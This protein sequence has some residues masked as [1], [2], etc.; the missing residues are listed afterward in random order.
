MS[1]NP[2]RPSR[3][4]VVR[5]E[6]FTDLIQHVKS[7]M[8]D[9][10]AMDPEAGEQVGTSIVEFLSGHWAGVTMV[11]PKDYQF[12]VAKRDLEIYQSHKGDF[13]DTA[14]TWGMTERGVRKV[15]ERVTKRIIQQRQ[16]RLFD[17]ADAKV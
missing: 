2:F 6:M 12:Q 15:I 16:G 13:T 8:V 14:R 10:Y 4:E 17:D 5:H 3:M 7:L 1:K 11:I 9:D